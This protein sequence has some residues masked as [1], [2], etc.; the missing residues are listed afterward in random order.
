MGTIEIRLGE[1]DGGAYLCCYWALDLCRGTSKRCKNAFFH[2]CLQSD[3]DMLTAVVEVLKT[4]EKSVEQVQ[5]EAKYL[6]HTCA[7]YVPG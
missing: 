7:W 1:R 5:L 3:D 6:M 4:A 2:C